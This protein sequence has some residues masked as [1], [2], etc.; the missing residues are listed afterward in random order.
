[1][2]EPLALSLQEKE[3]R[4][5]RGRSGRHCGGG[6]LPGLPQREGQEWPGD[7]GEGSGSCGAGTGTGSRYSARYYTRR[8]GCTE[9]L[10]REA[11]WSG[12]GGG[13]PGYAGREAGEFRRCEGECGRGSVV[14]RAVVGG[15]VV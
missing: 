10:G 5:G 2:E 3:R 14:A 15:A 13:E 1:M 9:C 4:K 7:H 8:I 11:G 6:Q 12:S